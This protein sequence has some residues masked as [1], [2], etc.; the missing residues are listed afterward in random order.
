MSNKVQK[1]LET[2]IYV[3]L[4]FILSGTVSI[5]TMSIVM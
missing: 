3:L 4:L 2:T 1:I 5:L